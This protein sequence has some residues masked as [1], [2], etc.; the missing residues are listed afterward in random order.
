[1][2]KPATSKISSALPKN[3]EDRLAEVL[4]SKVD[5]RN[6]SQ[7]KPR[8]DA[9]TPTR[10]LSGGG[11]GKAKKAPASAK[12]KTGGRSKPAAAGTG[13]DGLARNPRLDGTIGHRAFAT[14][15]WR[16]LP[17]D[18]TAALGSIAEQA[19]L[20]ELPKQ[21]RTSK[22]FAASLA[23]YK[24]WVLDVLRAAGEGQP[25][26][27]KAL[28]NAAARRD[29]VHETRVQVEL[30][31]DAAGASKGSRVE[32]SIDL[33]WRDDAGLWHLLDYK[34]TKDDEV[35]PEHLD[36]LIA[37]YYPQV[38]LYARAIDGRLPDGARLASYGLWFVKSGHVVTWD[39]AATPTSTS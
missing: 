24:D 14:W 3:T 36:E 1:V 7:E 2:E 22:T 5:V 30:A 35:E 20:D 8:A 11:A 12:K 33:L 29:V 38:S 4:S 32:G 17:T 34:V 6:P 19:I 26:L 27:A 37:K 13:S 39:V 18:S 16:A 25:E 23:H 28:V 10:T 15:A 9:P 31:P 21:A